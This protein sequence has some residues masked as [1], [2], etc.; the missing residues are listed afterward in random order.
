MNLHQVVTGVIQAVNPSLL[1]TV[2]TSTGVLPSG[3]IS[4]TGAITDTTLTISDVVSGAVMLGSVI[5]GDNV[6]QSTQITEFLSGDGGA[7]T[8][9][10][11]QSQTAAA[12]AITSTGDGT[13]IPQFST[14]TGVPMQVQALTAEDLKHIDGLNQQATMRAVYINGSL[15]GLNRAALRGGDILLIPTNLTGN[16]MDTYLVKSVIEGWDADGWTK[17][18]VVLQNPPVDQ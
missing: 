15:Q 1:G 16:S 6:L 3:V 12:A 9:T 13:Q 14:T 17:V 5:Y 11:N 10:V 2:Q 8:Y 7:G 4:A 18:A